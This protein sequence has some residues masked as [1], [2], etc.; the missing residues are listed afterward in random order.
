MYAL[1]AVSRQ[2]EM[3]CRD[4]AHMGLNVNAHFLALHIEDHWLQKRLLSFIGG[5]PPQVNVAFSGSASLIIMNINAL[6]GLQVLF[7]YRSTVPVQLTSKVFLELV[8]HPPS[9]VVQ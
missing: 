7:A 4:S 5:A 1:V 8:F 9:A 3:K 2:R 6:L